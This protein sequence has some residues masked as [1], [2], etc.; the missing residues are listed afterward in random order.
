MIDLVLK[1]DLNVKWLATGELPVRL[2]DQPASG[3]MLAKGLSEMQ[4]KI[5]NLEI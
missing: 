5:F 2:K 3:T 4:A 1:F